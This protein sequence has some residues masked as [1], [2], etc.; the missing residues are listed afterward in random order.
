MDFG[1]LYLLANGKTSVK[2]TSS[3][4]EEADKPTV[5]IAEKAEDLDTGTNKA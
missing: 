5:D 3:S 1:N 4:A 2:Q